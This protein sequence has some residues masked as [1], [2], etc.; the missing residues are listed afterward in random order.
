MWKKK[1]EEEKK[2]RKRTRNVL[3]E[4]SELTY[5][6]NVFK[7]INKK[8]C[9]WKRAAA[10]TK[11]KNIINC[12]IF[13]IIIVVV[14]WT[15]MNAMTM[16]TDCINNLFSR[17]Y[18]SLELHNAS[19]RSF[20]WS[21]CAVQNLFSLANFIKFQQ[22]IKNVIIWSLFKS[23]ASAAWAFFM[24]SLTHTN[25]LK[26]ALV[27]VYHQYQQTANLSFSRLSHSTAELSHEKSFCDF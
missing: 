19:R 3:A 12:S 9:I 4:I 20:L 6:K 5:T 2:R 26:N 23:F 18:L 1:D 24:T 22:K 17:L 7:K 16:T 11:N 27:I 10:R 8:S 21:F 13:I 25:K 14:C 15:T